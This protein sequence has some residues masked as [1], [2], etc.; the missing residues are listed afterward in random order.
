MNDYGYDDPDDPSDADVDE[1]VEARESVLETHRVYQEARRR[2]DRANREKRDREEEGRKRAAEEEAMNDSID[3]FYKRGP[4][5]PAARQQPA[6]PRG[7]GPAERR[8][9]SHRGGLAARGIEPS[10]E[11]DELLAHA[12]V[13][14]RKSAADAAEKAQR[15]GS[16]RRL[17]GEFLV[18][19]ARLRAFLS[20]GWS[21]GELREELARFRHNEPADIKNIPAAEF[22]AMRRDMRTEAFARSRTDDRRYVPPVDTMGPF[23]PSRMSSE[24]FEAYIAKE[25]KAANKRLIKTGR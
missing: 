19:A 24:D 14:D 18:P 10:P 13:L 7:P 21:L 16:I 23:S 15:E 20:S 1:E 17:S 25:R 3:P 22:E 9:I 6:A 2:L 8:E 11:S 4:N 12:K 5:R